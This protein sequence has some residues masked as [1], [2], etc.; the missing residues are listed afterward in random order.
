MTALRFDICVIGAGAGGLSVAAGAAQMG[1]R[2][3]LIEGGRMGGDC[4]NFGCV[5]SKALLAA[6]R[7]GRSYPEAVAHVAA[8]I[9]A[10]A[11]RDGE[12]R[13]A[14]LGVRVIR[15]W[16]RFVS[17]REVEAGGH[18]V[19]A[20]RFVIATGARPSVPDVPGFADVPF[21]TNESLFALREAPGHLL[22]LGGG[23]TGMEMAQAHRRLGC[24][25]TVI[26]AGRVL[27]R[28][29]PELAALVA[30]RLRAEGVE[31]VE[32]AAAARVEGWTGRV[33]VALSDGRR[34][35]GTHLLLAAGRQPALEGLGLAA[36]GI[37]VEAGRVKVS[38]GL[39]TANR[40]VYAIGDA[41]SAAQFAHGAGYQ[42]GIVVRRA[43]L[44][45][46]ARARAG[47]IPR[48]TYT[49]PELAA[50][51]MGEAEARARFG[52][53]LS[54]V[55][56]PLAETD[57][58]V[59]DGIGEGALKLMVVRGRPVGVAIAGPGAGELI[60]P[61]ALMLSARLPLS[62]MAKAVLPYPTLGEVSK[63]AAGAYFSP[64]LFDNPWLRWV[65]RAV[66]HVVP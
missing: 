40:R 57:R 7:Q 12:E 5:P 4:L 55:A 14:A 25:V 11:P 47:H 64:K 45:L 44:G 8:A 42:A 51:G 2:V 19:R 1:A 56:V 53:R 50:V 30:A 63:R 22:V 62:A 35:E 61:W 28:E 66:Q 41:A 3:A 21:L 20:R 48:V 13:F 32:G 39:R 43:V 16:A 6:A 60:A 58:A 46:P 37:A 33:V 52:A 54:V 36:A 49:E 18:R 17:P 10:L 23:P 15:G 65:V 24:A 26:E 59:T 29:E 31:I 27:G 34:V 38:A 9:A